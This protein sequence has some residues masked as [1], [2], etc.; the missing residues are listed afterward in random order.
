M[1]LLNIPVCP[2]SAEDWARVFPKRDF[3]P[4]D[5][6][7]VEYHGCKEEVP[8]GASFVLVGGVLSFT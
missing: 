5:L 2:S 4:V 1:D 7:G 3:G 8:P 6:C